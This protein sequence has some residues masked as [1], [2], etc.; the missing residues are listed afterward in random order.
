MGKLAL[1]G[2]KSGWVDGFMRIH[3]KMKISKNKLT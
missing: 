2:I 3:L 1:S